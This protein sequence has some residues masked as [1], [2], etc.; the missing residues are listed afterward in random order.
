M[1]RVLFATIATVALLAGSLNAADDKDKK[2]N[3]AA[4]PFTV[5]VVKVDGKKGEIT[6]KYP[7]DEKGK[8]QQKT[9]QLTRDVR[10]F[11]ETGRV[12][13]IDIFEAGT[14][15]FIVESEGTLKELRRAG[16]VAR[17][18]TLADHV[19]TLL[20]MSA[21]D[22]TAAEEVQQIYDMLR[23]LDTAKNGKID[24]TAL[25]A[26]ADKILKER[27][28]AIFDRLDVNKD[29]KISKEEAKGLIKEHFEKLDANKDGFIDFE[30]LLKAA[31][32]KR[33]AKAAEKE[34]E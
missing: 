16:Q 9:F 13:K 15:A 28:K 8:E 5:T 27:V 32:E 12:A 30:E 1:F 24:P 33:E 25:K 26:E 34:K 23:K 17:H 14:E 29:G 3:P 31:K 22:E 4:K 10:L 20:E 18:Q 11:D 2:D 6:V 21:S 7:A 19:R